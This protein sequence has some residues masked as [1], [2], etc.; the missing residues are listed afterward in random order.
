MNTLPRIAILVI[1]FFVENAACFGANYTYNDST[2][3]EGLSLRQKANELRYKFPDSSITLLEQSFKIFIEEKDTIQAANSLLAKAHVFENNANY[4]KSYDAYW[5]AMML[6]DNFKN[7]NIRSLIYHRL[8]RIYSYYKREDEALKYLIKALT[9]RKASIKIDGL[10]KS[11]LIPYYYF[12]ASTYRELNKP[13]LAKKYVDSC[14]QIMPVKLKDF[15]KELVDFEHAYVLSQT[16]KEVEAIQLME[17]IYPWFKSNLPSYLVLFYKQWGDMYLGLNKLS[18]SEDFYM[19]SLSISKA[20]NSHKDFTPLVHEKLTE[21]YLK[22]NDYNNAFK[23]LKLAKEL[24]ERFFDSRSKN[25]QSLLEIKDNYRIEKLKQEAHIKEQYLKQLEQEEEIGNLQRIILLVS[26]VFIA[27]LAF[28]YVKHL[29]TKHNA[30]KALIKKN[31]ELENKKTQELLELKNKELA[32]SA[33]QLIEKEEFLKTLKSKVR[34]KD[35]KIKVHEVN[36]VLRSISVSN[37]QN[38]E[39]F[40]LRF[41][42]VNKEFYKKMFDKF[43]NLSQGDQKIC[44]LIKLNFSS[45]DMARLLGISVES[46]HTSRHRIRKKMN[47][48][49]SVNLEDYINS[50]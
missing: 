43:P 9:L 46:V 22:K 38:W 10:D 42:D 39:E 34:V 6:T 50:L 14:Y 41:I 29:R 11:E 1:A 26:V 21:M 7:H 15:S 35:E 30:E 48:S 23:H 36:K 13:S 2:N 25:N 37:N 47:L 40:K 20:F 12:L 17:H 5:S 18:I 3:V 49:R 27:V 16:E 31:Q 32:A 33:L 44:A 45:K 24:N 4:S 8:G 19:K 28:I